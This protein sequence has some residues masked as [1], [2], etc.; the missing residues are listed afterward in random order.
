MKGVM[1]NFKP[2]DNVIISDKANVIPTHARGKEGVVE[3]ILSR[4][5]Y[6]SQEY[7]IEGKRISKPDQE[8]IIYEVILNHSGEAIPVAEPD[9]IMKKSC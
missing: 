8:V 3:R 7:L 9:L 2:G 1:P 5:P 6:T 4:T